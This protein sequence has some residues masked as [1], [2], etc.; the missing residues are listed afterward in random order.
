MEPFS[1]RKQIR[2]PSW[3][4]G[5]IPIDHIGDTSGS[6]GRG[7]VKDPEVFVIFDTD[8]EKEV[9]DQGKGR[10]ISVPLAS[11][12][13]Q[14]PVVEINSDINDSEGSDK[15][16]VSNQ[17]IS[18]GYLEVEE[19]SERDAQPMDDSSFQLNDT[20]TTDISSS[21]V[22]VMDE[23]YLDLEVEGQIEM[24]E[25]DDEVDKEPRMKK[26]SE[27]QKDEP[28]SSSNSAKSAKRKRDIP[29]KKCSIS[30]L[31]VSTIC[32]KTKDIPYDSPKTELCNEDPDFFSW[33]DEPKIVDK[34]DHEKFIDELWA[35]FDFLMC[36]TN[37]GFYNADKA[38]ESHS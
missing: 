7:G 25:E 36:S 17:K 35:D 26:F 29:S 3:E 24:L 6:I 2:Q 20:Y 18:D 21:S 10:Q 16:N 5:S 19:V 30:K 14:V 38:P 1:K 31:L 11:S 33:D 8:E 28:S 27:P 23:T 34:S 13:S 4:T 32:N 12:V 15:G 37:I 22:E 9:E